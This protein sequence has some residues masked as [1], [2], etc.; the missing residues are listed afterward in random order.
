MTA[1]LAACG[2]S[3]DVYLWLL[4]HHHLFVL[5][6]DGLVVEPDVAEKLKWGS[7][8]KNSRSVVG[9]LESMPTCPSCTLSAVPHFS[10]REPREISCPILDILTRIPGTS[11]VAVSSRPDVL[12]FHT[13]RPHQLSSSDPRRRAAL[14]VSAARAGVL[15][16]TSI[17]GRTGPPP[18]EEPEVPHGPSAPSH[19]RAVWTRFLVPV[20]AT[21]RALD[22]LNVE[23]AKFWGPGRWL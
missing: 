7:V 2:S 18:A 6:V 17:R 23:A 22:L 12:A 3:A 20:A 4:F 21:G 16:P 10:L 11:R 13:T 19:P 9:G 8:S 5:S 14:G 1:D 15:L